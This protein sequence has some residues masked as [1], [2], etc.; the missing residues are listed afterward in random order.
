MGRERSWHPMADLPGFLQRWNFIERAKLE[1]ELWDAFEQGQ[2]LD[3]LLSDCQ[4]AV[5]AGAKDR[6]FQLEVW[7]TS[8]ERIRK[9]EGI[10][11]GKQ[12]PPAPTED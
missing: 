3:A 12:A 9:I 7:Q 10:M 4:Q 8:L 6:A 11:R 1:R 2:D 5:A